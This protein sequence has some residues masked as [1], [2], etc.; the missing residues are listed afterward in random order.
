MKKIK[1]NNYEENLEGFEK[2]D[3]KRSLIPA[4]T[5]VDFSARIQSVSAATNRKFYDLI[6]KFEKI[7]NCPILIN[8]SFNVRGEPIVCSPYDAYKCFMMTDLDIL[9]I[10]NYI[11][12]KKEQ[13]NLNKDKYKFNYHLD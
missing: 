1:I 8:T 11:L 3:V 12:I 10:E 9:I 4:V 13:I 2:L 5:H 7:T 6:S